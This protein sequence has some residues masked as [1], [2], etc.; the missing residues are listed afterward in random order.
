MTA[1]GLPAEKVNTFNLAEN[2]GPTDGVSQT[3]TS[4][5]TSVLVTLA[6]AGRNPTDILIPTQAGSEGPGGDD[7]EDDDVAGGGSATSGGILSATEDGEDGKSHEVSSSLGGKI[8]GGIGTAF[9]AVGHFINPFAD[10]IQAEQ[11]AD[12]RIALYCLDE[13]YFVDGKRELIGYLNLETMQVERDGNRVTLASVQRQVAAWTTSD[14]AAW[15]RDPDNKIREEPGDQRNM[16]EDRTLESVNGAPDPTWRNRIST[17][18]GLAEELAKQAVYFNA[19]GPFCAIASKAAAAGDLALGERAIQS[20]MSAPLVPESAAAARLTTAEG[21]I[22]PFGFTNAA[23]YNAF[24]KTLRAG[25]GAEVEPVFQGSAVTGRN[26][27]TGVLFDVG[28][29]SDFDIGLVNQGL[30]ER[31]R[32]LGLRMKTGPNRI[33]P[34]APRS[35]LAIQLGLDGALKEL[36]QLSGG[37]P[38]SFVLYDTLGQALKRPSL[39]IPGG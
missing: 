38:V 22:V 1:H 9:G 29:V 8:L 33:G 36:S 11:T 30:F 24:A 17:A 34:I 18:Q 5:P 7:D 21:Y 19:M 20:G 12:G 3:A 23:E 14:W 10:S 26:C 13:G 39:V 35:D 32:A 6:A 16:M 27:E 15:M 31:A 2:N 25:V 37:R 4:P 28:R